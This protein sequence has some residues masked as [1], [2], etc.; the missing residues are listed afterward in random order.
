MEKNIDFSKYIHQMAL[1]ETI[2]IRHNATITCRREGWL[3]Q[4]NHPTKGLL[5]WFV[6][7]N[8]VERK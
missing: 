5:R 7:Y 4:F 2:N 3:C 6:S 1:N 8:Q